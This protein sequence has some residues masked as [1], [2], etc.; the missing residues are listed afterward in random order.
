METQ[1][2][3]R[4]TATS[5][6]ASEQCTQRGHMLVPND[7]K[8]IV[9]VTRMLVVAHRDERKHNCRLCDTEAIR[10]KLQSKNEF[11]RHTATY[12]R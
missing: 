7:V 6:V 12:S 9:L 10:I 8:H 5:Y 3:Q 2:H 4:T 11:T 1:T